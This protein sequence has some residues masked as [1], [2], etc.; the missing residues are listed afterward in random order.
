MPPELRARLTILPKPLTTDQSRHQCG[1]LSVNPVHVLKSAWG[2]W[3][4]G[5]KHGH[6]GQIVL[7]LTLVLQLPDTQACVSQTLLD[8]FPP[9]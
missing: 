8:P 6:E 9:V 1:S 2:V 4:G 3:F 5:K 7:T